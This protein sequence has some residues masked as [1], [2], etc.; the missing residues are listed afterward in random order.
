MSASEDVKTLFRRFGGEAD[1]YQE[2][3]RDR[4]ALQSLGKW[5]ML[6]QVNLN[7][8]PNISNVRYALKFNPAN[9]I[10]ENLQKQP[11]KISPSK[12][13]AIELRNSIAAEK[14]SVADEISSQNN[15]LSTN[16]VLEIEKQEQHLD[17]TYKVAEIF[18]PVTQLVSSESIENVNTSAFSTHALHSEVQSSAS[19]LPNQE[20][21]TKAHSLSKLFGRLVEP[22]TSSTEAG[23]LRRKYIK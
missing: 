19:E 8:L 12:N 5:A 18:E 7:E 23:V 16:P 14:L 20:M 21:P 4:Q 13:D 1:T 2:I 3:V 9:T 15:I 11:I 6:S 22:K 10:V 17:Q